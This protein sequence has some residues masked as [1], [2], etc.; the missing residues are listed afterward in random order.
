[1]QTFCSLQAAEASFWR[2]LL[3]E[4]ASLHR[5]GRFERICRGFARDDLL[6]CWRL[7]SDQQWL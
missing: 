2:S 7:W 1:V 6:L 3:L 4:W 5:R